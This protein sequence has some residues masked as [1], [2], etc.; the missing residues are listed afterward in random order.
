MRKE[1]TTQSSNKR[2]EEKRA[3][4]MEPRFERAALS[5]WLGSGAKTGYDATEAG[6]GS[7]DAGTGPRTEATTE[8]A[9]MI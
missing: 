2:M 5:I 6:K 7:C 3:T 8:V 9:T 1:G 4:G